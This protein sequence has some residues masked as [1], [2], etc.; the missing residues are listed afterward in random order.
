MCKKK[1]KSHHIGL[2]TGYILRANDNMNSQW[3]RTSSIQDW[4]VYMYQYSKVN[5]FIFFFYVCN[6]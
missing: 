1:N 2:E 6:I 4:F 3:T 5:L